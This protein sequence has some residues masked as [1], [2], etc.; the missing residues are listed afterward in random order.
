M[1][2]TQPLKAIE[3]LKELED[4]KK[5]NTLVMSGCISPILVA[6]MQMFYNVDKLVKTGTKRSFAVCDTA[7]IFNVTPNCVYRAIGKLK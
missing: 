1:E 6:H 3:I 7:A 4:S 5:L 2:I